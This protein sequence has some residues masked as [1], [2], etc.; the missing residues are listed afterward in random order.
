MGSLVTA[1]ASY[2]D[3][4]T[5][6]GQWLVRIEDLDPL[7]ETDQ[8]R[9]QILTSLEVHGL[10]SDEPIRYQSQC[11]RRYANLIDE[12]IKSGMAYPC[13]CSRKQ[14][15]ANGGRHPNH[16]RDAPKHPPDESPIAIR[17]A[18]TEELH[19]WTDSLQGE[20]TQRI[21][22]ELDDPV[23]RRK[24][25]F[26]SYQLAVVA[27]DIDQNI[28]H[29]VRG[30]DMLDLTPQQCQIYACLGAEPPQWMHIPLVMNSDGQKLSKQNHA[31]ALDDTTPQA[32]LLT[33]LNLLK[34]D[35]IDLHTDQTVADILSR[36]AKRWDPARIHLTAR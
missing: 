17:F 24:E 23:I 29:V 22:A 19:T 34:Q 35:T 12:L 18:L 5:H 14:L 32:N 27:D 1:L 8:A 4:R 31:P 28:T 3:A 33:A 26:Y 13:A 11:L 16:C 10:K 25:G 30:A 15:K 2:L 9:D 20:L 21:H 36:A 7:R 6:H